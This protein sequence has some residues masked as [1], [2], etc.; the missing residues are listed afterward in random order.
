MA[1]NQGFANW[2]DLS[3]PSAAAARYRE[4]R[5]AAH[6]LAPEGTRL[7]FFDSESAGRLMISPVAGYPE[8]FERVLLSV[9]IF[10]GGRLQAIFHSRDRGNLESTG[11]SEV[12]VA[13]V[14]D[15]LRKWATDLSW[16]QA[17]KSKDPG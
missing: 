10:S 15:F 14:L 1:I 13:H 5:S 8:R 6:Q 2:D 9:E 11:P 3:G 4:I 7:G 16:R 12:V 17:W